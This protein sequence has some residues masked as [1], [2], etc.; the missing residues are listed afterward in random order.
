MIRQYINTLEW[1]CINFQYYYKVEIWK[2]GKVPKIRISGTEY[3]LG[4]GEVE[5]NY[6]QLYVCISQ[7]AV[8]WV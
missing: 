8:Q 6:I 1:Q 2:G 5:K 3:R 7:S 4:K